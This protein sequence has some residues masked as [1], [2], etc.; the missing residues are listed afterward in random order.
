MNLPPLRSRFFLL[1]CGCWCALTL[2]AQAADYRLEPLDEAAPA[3]DLSDEVAARLQSTG[4]RIIRGASRTLCDLW[5][6]KELPGQSDFTPTLAV[7]YPFNTGELI[8]VVRFT[9][10]SEDFRGQDIKAGVYTLR[11]GLQPVDGNHV[12]TS[13]TRDFLLLLSAGDDTS[14][15][16]MDEFE[17]FQMSA[18]AVGTTHPGMLSLLAVRDDDRDRPSLDHDEPRELWYVRLTADCNSAGESQQLPIDLVIVGRAP[19]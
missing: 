17:M 4:V 16:V 8:G 2:A 10:N 13:D 19:E 5:L 9:S 3:E 7:L 12:G 14:A 6:A 15:A 11:F 18:D 1:A